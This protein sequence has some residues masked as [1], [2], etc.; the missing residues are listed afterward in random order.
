MKDISQKLTDFLKAHV[1]ATQYMGLEVQHY[2][3]KTLQ[4][5]APLAP[6]INDKNTAFGGSLY[7]LCVMSCWG[8]L[9][10]K[11]QEKGIACNQVVMQSSINYYA[12]VDDTIVAT[13]ES[14]DPAVLDDFF[15]RFTNT[16]RAKISLQSHIECNG[17]KAVSFEGQYALLKNTD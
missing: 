7:C 4:L 3:G 6:N 2:D 1:P 11:T 10:L 8:M 13:C 9:Y 5:S 16:G 12:P 14:P 15:N 17:K